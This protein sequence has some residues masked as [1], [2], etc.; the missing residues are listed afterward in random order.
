MLRSVSVSSVVSGRISLTAPTSV[1]LPTPKPPATRTF[2][3]YGTTR[4]RVVPTAAPPAVCARLSERPESIDH[5]QEDAFI[6]W[7]TH[8]LRVEGRHEASLQQVADQY[9]DHAEWKVHSA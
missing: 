8:S 2:N 1:V 7:A 9:A 6:R 4:A 3:A 5:R